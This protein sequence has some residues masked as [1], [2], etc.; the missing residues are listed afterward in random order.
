[1]KRYCRFAD[2]TCE[3][4]ELIET[5]RKLDQHLKGSRLAKTNVS[6]G[7]IEYVDNV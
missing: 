3:Q 2:C 1:H 7:V 4:C 5:R 6:K